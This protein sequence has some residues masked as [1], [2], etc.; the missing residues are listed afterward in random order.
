MSK[1][2]GFFAG[3]V[4]FNVL[5]VNISVLNKLRSLDVRNIKICGER[6]S[7]IVPILYAETVRCLLRNFEYSCAENINIIRGVNFLINRFVLS[8]AIL[9]CCFLYLFADRFIYSV[10]VVGGDDKLRNEINGYLYNNGIKKYASKH[11]ILRSNIADVIAQTYPTVAHANVK[12]RGNTAVIT[13]AAAEYNP[14]QA[15]QNLYARYDAVI[16]QIWVSGG[17]AVV[18]IGDVVKK[19]D[20]LVKNAYIGKAVVMGEVRFNTFI[21]EMNIV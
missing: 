19:G 11:K 8:A 1:I 6:V 12:I 10:R 20:L 15:P 17:T 16:K 18:G 4:R 21:F 13:V 3:T 2:K 9:L 5:G 7:F 14:V